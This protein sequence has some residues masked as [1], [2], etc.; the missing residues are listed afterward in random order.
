VNSAAENSLTTR[1]QRL[2]EIS[3]TFAA[4][5]D[6]HT[7]LN[8]IVRDSARFCRAQ[9]AALSLYDPARGEL[10]LCASSLRS[11]HRDRTT[12]PLE[13][14][15]A[16][17]VVAHRQPYRFAI[18]A[19][20]TVSYPE[21]ALQ[22]DLKPHSALAVPLITGSQLLGVLEVINHSQG[23][24]SGEDQELLQAL[25][26]QA[27]VAIHNARLF[28]QSDLISELVHE[29]HTPLTSMNAAAH[30]L[31]S[32]ETPEPDRARM[33]PI[34]ANEIER[35]V[36]LTSSYLDLAHLESGRSQ[37]HTEDVDLRALLL[38][39][40]GLMQPRAAEQGLELVLD[41]APVLPRLPGDPRQLKQVVVNL[42]SNAIKYNRPGGSIVL[43]AKPVP[44]GGEGLS[45][46]F[47]EGFTEVMLEVSDTGL[48]IPAD[49]LPRLFEKFFRAPGAEKAARGSGLGLS[50]TQHLVGLHGGRIEVESVEGSGS[51]LR[52]YLPLDARR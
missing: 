29:L 26:A 6:L 3:R 47:G 10:L 18:S 21:A 5:L 13:G 23:E 17:W 33:A 4:T 44:S 25:G 19:G 28:Q 2:L 46:G 15:L 50:I 51:T 48:G 16:G 9:A 35:L 22:P 37:F 7:L 30:L 42:L 39:S 14:S 36:E 49:S 34:I 38:E 8:H 43:R 40:A 45:E 31:L 11:A 41:I 24:F 27:A 20:E 12:L 1:C 52:V 32:P